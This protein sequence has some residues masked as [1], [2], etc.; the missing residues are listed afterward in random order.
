MPYTVPPAPLAAMD[1]FAVVSSATGLAS[2]QEPVTLYDAKRV[3]TGNVLPSGCDAVIIIEDVWEGGD[4][5]ITSIRKSVSPMQH[6]RPA[7]EDVTAG[8]IVIPT[9]HCIRPFDIGALCCVWIYHCPGLWGVCRPDPSGSEL[10]PAG[11]HP[12]PGQVV[13][14]NMQMTAAYMQK[15]GVSSVIYPLTPDEPGAITDVVMQAVTDHEMVIISA[16]SSAGTRDFTSQV[17]LDCG[18]ILFH[19]VSVKPGKPVYA[20][21]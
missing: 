2:E 3:N 1:G 16:G 11:V 5:S 12:K 8:R 17:I 19:G 4:G 14:S 18:E 20:G 13:E 9:G 10:V 15:I 7:G 21:G 6:V